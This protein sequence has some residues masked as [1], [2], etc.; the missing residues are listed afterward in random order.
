[1]LTSNKNVIYF[2][3]DKKDLEVGIQ[4]LRL[5]GR[6]HSSKGFRELIRASRRILFYLK[7]RVCSLSQ[8]NDKSHA[9][10]I[11]GKSSLKNKINLANE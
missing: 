7:C 9:I 6:S 2:S 3:D 10:I 5:H 1:M 11:L 8:V 4:K